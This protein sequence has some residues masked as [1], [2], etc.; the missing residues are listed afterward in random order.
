VSGNIFVGGSNGVLYC[1]NATTGASCGTA[2]VGSGGAGGG[3]VDAPIVDSTEGEVFTEANNFTASC[4]SPTMTGCAVLTQISTS[5]TNQVNVNMGFAA[6]TSSSTYTDLYDGAFGNA[7]LTT[8]TGYMYFCGNLT[9]AATPALWRVAIT[10]GIMATSNNGTPIQLVESGSTGTAYDCSP[11]TEFYNANT[12]PTPLDFLFIG[13]KSNSIPCAFNEC[14]AS[15][16]LSSTFPVPVASSLTITAGG[17]G[18]SGMVVD[19]NSTMTG[20]SQI[21]FG[22]LNS[23]AGEQISQAALQ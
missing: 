1:I 3:I 4:T 10:N 2:V 19:N 6:S 11:L 7:Y 5:M 18:T 9:T 23:S 14:I 8:H 22:N 15:Y 21:Y 12:T 20:A 13:L 17:K 16:D